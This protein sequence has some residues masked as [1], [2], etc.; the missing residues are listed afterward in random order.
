MTSAWGPNFYVRDDVKMGWYRSSEGVALV[1]S[2]HLFDVCFQFCDKDFGNIDVDINP[3]GGNTHL[4]RVAKKS[5]CY[6]W[7]SFFK[8]GVGKDD[9]R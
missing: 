8:I 7:N 1:G 3:V 4:S 6:F 9:D 2:I 5:I